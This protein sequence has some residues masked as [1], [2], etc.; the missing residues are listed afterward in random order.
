MKA[1]FEVCSNMNESATPFCRP[2]TLT[3]LRLKWPWRFFHV[4]F[5]LPTKMRDEKSCATL[6]LPFLHPILVKKN[7]SRPFW[8]PFSKCGRQKKRHQ[9]D[10][11]SS[12]SI[13]CRQPF[14]DFIWHGFDKVAMTKKRSQKGCGT[15][16][17][18]AQSR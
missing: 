4:L 7:A 10:V 1:L 2:S 5:L 8:R 6:L 3:F 12:A 15:R 18:C 17:I 14:L 9:K 11:K 13:F 16:G